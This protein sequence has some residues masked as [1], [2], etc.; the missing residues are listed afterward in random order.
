M[1][2]VIPAHKLIV[3]V[4]PITTTVNK[5][6]SKSSYTSSSCKSMQED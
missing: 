6:I 2:V 5:Q 3:M 1:R 4:N